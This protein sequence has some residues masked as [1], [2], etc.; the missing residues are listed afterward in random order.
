MPWLEFEPTTLVLPGGSAN[1]LDHAV[2]RGGL[3]THGPPGQ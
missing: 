3:T 1:P 2:T